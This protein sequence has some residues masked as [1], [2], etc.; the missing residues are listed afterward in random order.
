MIYTSVR[1]NLKDTYYSILILVRTA[2]RSS[3]VART[4]VR[5]VRAKILCTIAYTGGL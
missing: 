4:E 1:T 5:T 2:V 3:Q